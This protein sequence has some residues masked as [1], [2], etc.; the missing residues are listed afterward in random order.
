MND[1]TGRAKMNKKLREV[2]ARYF[3]DLLRHPGVLLVGTGTD[4]LRIYFDQTV[5]GAD[6]KSLPQTLDGVPVRIIPYI[7]PKETP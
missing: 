2:K 7:V 4:Y 5:E 6:I 1:D 3:V